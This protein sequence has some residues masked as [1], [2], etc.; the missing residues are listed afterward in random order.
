MG[1][2]TLAR[3]AWL[4]LGYLLFVIV[5]G[6]WVRI[7]FSG[8]G[9]GDHWPLCGG[10]VV[11][12]APSLKTIIEFTHRLTS[13]LGLIAVGWLVW[14]IFKTT[15]AGHA[16][17]PAAVG[18]V[19]FILA[20]AAL[21]AALVKFELVGQ[22]DSVARGVVVALHLVNT[23]SFTA[24]GA[25]TAYRLEYPKA[26][27]WTG[28][29][30]L[31][32]RLGLVGLVITGMTG[33]VTALGDTLFPVAPGE[34]GDLLTRIREDATAGQH[35]LIRLRFIHPVIAALVALGIAWTAAW[36][37]ATARSPQVVRLARRLL[38]LLAVQ[39]VLG[40]VTIALAAPAWLQLSHLLMAQL[41][42]IT[43]VVL[44]AAAS[45]EK[46]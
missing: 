5:W 22:D 41:T 11:P 2:H 3:S 12:T 6:A 32:L 29:L 14:R 40:V 16:A 37:V 35:F 46:L 43:F 1:T 36:F 44:G 26:A 42:W 28:R 10:E 31:V 18:C 17:R 8:N 33:A 13:G 21:G 24:F 34:S 30:A 27:P 45:D 39:V 20:E 19:G 38:G 9:C 7:S 25:M 15:E 4:I 23:L